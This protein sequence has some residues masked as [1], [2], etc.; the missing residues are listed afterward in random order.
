M[1]SQSHVVVVTKT[2]DGSGLGV[3][4]LDSVQDE[5]VV[6]VTVTGGTES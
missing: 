3:E 1:E 6:N 4:L 5:V 2:V